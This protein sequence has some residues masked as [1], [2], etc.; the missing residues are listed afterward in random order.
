MN[1]A[2]RDWIVIA[3]RDKLKGKVL[4]IGSFIVA[5][6][7]QISMRKALTILDHE[8][9]GI[10][11]REGNGVD[12]VV[13]AKKTDFEDESFD[14]IICL[15]TLEHVDWPRNLI[16]ESYRIMKPGGYIFLAT[17]MDFP[18]HDYPSD[19]WRFTPE[20][21][22]LLL[23]DAGYEVIETEGCGRHD[24]PGVVRAIGRK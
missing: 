20:C 12:I 2:N 9:V 8:M 1:D 14:T 13:D 23:D 4:E 6:Q 19:Y 11:M 24:F 22:R 3:H 10:D 16:H 17:V 15:D 21:L 18:I 7:E 5:G